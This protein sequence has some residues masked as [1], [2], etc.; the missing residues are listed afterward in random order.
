MSQAL[1]S[2]NSAPTLSAAEVFP[3]PTGPV[4]INIEYPE[5]IFSMYK[6]TPI[7]IGVF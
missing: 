4:I 2:E 1:K 6:K 7:I 3:A 5:S